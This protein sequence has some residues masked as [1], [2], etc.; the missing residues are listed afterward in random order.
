VGEVLHNTPNYEA[1][2]GAWSDLA[3]KGPL[4]L[5]I[6]PELALA[7]AAQHEG[8]SPD[9]T[10]SKKRLL[11]KD[12]EME[13][14]GKKVSRR[15]YLKRTG[16]AL[17]AA[18]ALSAPAETAGSG[19]EVMYGHGL[20]WN[21]DLPGVAGQLQLTFDLRANLETGIGFG[22]A[23]DAL[24]PEANIHFDITAAEKHG[25]MH[26]LRGKVI[27]ANDPNSVGLPVRI[28]AEK[29]GDATAVA[30]GV[31]NVAFAG[32]GLVVIAIIAVLIGLLL[33]A[34]QKV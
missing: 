3:K 13:E 18:S 4:E 21:R 23:S 33:P 30:I 22:T 12:T 25:N 32:A 1:E 10:F 34:V 24:H 5:P 9:G 29:R 8:S 28:L 7:R 31:G 20:V 26:T 6:R 15:S 17:V 27:R 2:D 19:G 14:T 11:R 16:G